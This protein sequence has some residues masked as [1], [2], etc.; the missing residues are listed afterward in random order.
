[1]EAFVLEFFYM[2]WFPKCSG[3][4]GFG[5]VYVYKSNNTRSSE[6]KRTA[7]KKR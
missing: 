6:C 7:S 4:Y 1:M 2:N 3:I 5:K